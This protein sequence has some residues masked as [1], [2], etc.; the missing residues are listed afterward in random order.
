MIDNDRVIDI[1]SLQWYPGRIRKQG[2]K[3]LYFKGAGF[4][5]S[6]VLAKCLPFVSQF[7]RETNGRRVLYSTFFTL[8]EMICTGTACISGRFS[9]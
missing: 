5:L 2:S 1:P 8:P 7:S 3:P 9:M 4:F 6:P